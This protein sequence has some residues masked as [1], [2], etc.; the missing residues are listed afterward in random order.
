MLSLL[1]RWLQHRKRSSRQSFWGLG[2]S[3]GLRDKRRPFAAE[4]AASPVLRKLEPRRVLSITSASLAGNGVL[5]ITLDGA[6]DNVTLQEN[7]GQLEVLDGAAVNSTFDPTQVDS[8]VVN[9]GGG[10]D[11]VTFDPTT[12]ALSLP[13]V[14]G[15]SVVTDSVENL[16]F[17]G[18]HS[19]D[20]DLEIN[21]G[22]VTASAGSLTVSGATN[23]TAGTGDVLLD[24]ASNDFATMSISTSGNVSVA[25]ANDVSIDSTAIDGDLSITS[26]TG[27]AFTDPGAD[28][29][30]GGNLTATANGGDITDLNNITFDID[31]NASFT[32]TGIIQLA[33]NSL[34]T[35]DVAGQATFNAGGDVVIQP[36]GP[37]NG[38]TALFGSL[39][40]T[41]VGN[42][43]V[44]EDDDTLLTDADVD[45]DLVLESPGQLEIEQADVAGN[46]TFTAGL[47]IALIG[48]GDVE[49]GGDLVANANG[50]DITDLDDITIDVEGNATFTATANIQLADDALN[51]LDVASAATFDAG[52]DIVIQPTG[53]SNGANVVIGSLSLT[54]IGNSTVSEDDGT[55]LTA[56]D[57][58]G[59]LLLESAGQLLVEQADVEGNATFIAGLGVAFI[60][61]GDDV[62]VGGNLIATANGG[63]ITDLNDIT[64]DVGGDATFTATGDIQLAD[65]SLNVLGVV[66]QATF[67][68][69]GNVIIQPA[70]TSNAATVSFGS[71]SLTSVGNSTVSEDDDT[72]LTDA[73]VDGDLVVESA[74]QLQIQQA[75]VEGNATFTAGVGIAF[76][77]PGDVEVG[78]NLIVA[79]NAGGISDLD[80]ITI[81]VEGAAT[82][83]ATSNIELADDALNVLD[84]AGQATFDAGGDVLVQPAGSINGANVVFGSLSLTSTGDS[85]VSEDDGTILTDA[86]VD[87]N[88]VLETAGQMEIEQA[89]V[90][91]NA[92]FT[93]GLGIA[94]IAPG[95]N[96]E[97]GGNLTATANGGDITDLNIITIDV[98]GDATFTASGNIQLADNSLNMLLVTGSA[99]FEAGGDVVIQRVG[100]SNGANVLFGSLSLTSAANSTVSEDNVTLL[101]DA[102]VEG[103]LVLESAAQ[104]QIAQADV[105]G[106]AT[107]TAAL[108]ITFI[109][110]GD[111]VEVGGNLSA[112]ANGGNITDLND[113]TIDV[114]GDAL[115][116]ASGNIL[117]ADNPANTI[118]VAGK[119]TFTAATLVDV[120]GAVG[121]TANFDSLSLAATD[122]TV[123]EDSDT[124]F[125]GVSVNN[126]LSLNSEAV[127]TQSSQAVIV[128]GNTT[129]DL[130][131]APAHVYLARASSRPATNDG[132]PVDNQFD[133]LL[134]ITGA[135]LTSD[136]H[137]RNT[138]A[139]ATFPLFGATTQFNNLEIWHTAAN[140]AIP[141]IDFDIQQDLTIRSDGGNVTDDANTRLAVGNNAVY[142]ASQNIT[143]IADALIVIMD[144]D[145]TAQQAISATGN[146]LDVD[147]LARFVSV[148]DDSIEVN[149]G[150]TTFG[151][152]NFDGGDVN[153]T[154]DDGTLL[155]DSSDAVN[156][157]LRS[158]GNIDDAAGSINTLN[159]A[160]RALIN[161]AG[162]IVLGN[163]DAIVTFGHVA[164][165]TAEYLVLNANNADLNVESNV[166]LGDDPSLEFELSQL[167]LNAPGLLI[168][169]PQGGA[170]DIIQAD[171]VDLTA[172]AI[173]LKDVDFSQFTA[174]ATGSSDVTDS[175][176]LRLEELPMDI[177]NTGNT[178]TSMTRGALTPVNPGLN[179]GR[180]TESELFTFEL[181]NDYGVVISNHGDLMVNELTSSQGSV[182]IESLQVLDALDPT[183]VLED[184]N[185]L[186][187]ENVSVMGGVEKA[188]T[189]VAEGTIVISDGVLLQSSTGI[190]TDVGAFVAFS[191]VVIPPGL[192]NVTSGPLLQ[193]TQPNDVLPLDADGSNTTRTLD[194]V[195]GAFYRLQ[196]EFEIGRLG[197]TNFTVVVAYVDDLA[198]IDPDAGVIDV[199]GETYSLTAL[200]ADNESFVVGQQQLNLMTG[201]DSTF[202]V[203]ID[204]LGNGYTVEFST[205]V[206]DQDPAGTVD[207][208][209]VLTKIFSPLFPGENPIHPE[210][211]VVIRAFNDSLI[212]LYTA[213]VSQSDA[214]D[215]SLKLDDADGFTDLNESRVDVDAIDPLE[216]DPGKT[217]K[218]GAD[219][220][221]P[222]VVML[223]RF[224]LEGPL[225]D[226]PR[227]PERPP[228]FVAPP[229]PLEPAPEL[230]DIP[231]E[232][233][234]DVRPFVIA[235]IEEVKYGPVD[236]DSG[237]FKTQPPPEVWEG[238]T[239]GN[240][241]QEI[242]DKIDSDDM[243][244]PGPYQIEVQYKDGSFEVYSHVKQFESALQNDDGFDDLSEF[245]HPDSADVQTTHQDAWQM[246]APPQDDIVNADDVTV[247][248]DN[249]GVYHQKFTTRAS[250]LTAVAI[251]A[252]RSNHGA[253]SEQDKIQQGIA[254]ADWSRLA[255]LRRK[256]ATVLL[257]S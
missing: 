25:D 83:T 55:L 191:D 34:N 188:L 218:P 47:G 189:A 102:D 224:P 74:G 73:D 233:F 131:S 44:S 158:A 91:G 48:P 213:D 125:D 194:V 221:P 39:S 98:E 14:G 197:E 187:S 105:E 69:G 80:N 212:N 153:I 56:A 207:N 126:N 225:P 252:C 164:T 100:P 257:N 206:V 163:E 8:I 70:G 256:I 110:P 220:S 40:I 237:K 107:V 52:G 157:V 232:E 90:E 104:L 208:V 33:D 53:S 112:A 68:A 242:K 82:F 193:F 106:N 67:N 43:T 154:E 20:A 190:V 253:R 211:P 215:I 146:Q 41:S 114:D 198:F 97:V 32:A 186:F 85:T 5:T 172:G 10:T 179:G 184:G 216:L 159:V 139:T 16:L 95:E 246:W 149:A 113:I 92:T 31:G 124:H 129:L 11:T 141:A 178:G 36:A 37:S 6:D 2:A 117:L 161:A 176:V 72:L 77:G 13:G 89:D 214:L 88:L 19:L 94:F 156:L 62:E 248:L 78:G 130:R 81:D 46:G 204:D 87:T 235:A 71:L 50:G 115:F 132:A 152:L 79:A 238:G 119:A 167:V 9:D 203:G 15:D 201:F 135:G 151:S 49:V 42:S 174:V 60:N 148:S 227:P 58:D 1:G 84:V 116:T 30:V 223:A 147:G 93:A 109:Q 35:L 228:L 219:L 180:G 185:L 183:I 241:V 65:N 170:T 245:Q 202:D 22:S 244:E 250:A 138:S 236:E 120:G 155:R 29:I 169:Q 205:R 101:T 195:D 26:A 192:I 63:D 54:S 255:R 144:A 127:I 123:D 66:G 12:N 128:N 222:G 140:V 150:T 209:A 59:D 230:Q 234:D 3:W 28:V 27:I 199:G 142:T 254:S 17:A 210:A 122:A 45:G 217:N 165:N 137:I 24:N 61:P 64:I 166:N 177:P 168:A 229:P 96:V 196:A 111:D 23:I 108:G 200:A 121:A 4:F 181:G 7:A 171:I 145:F 57:V 118:D 231:P 240:F 103:N 143:L 226:A 38:A 243:Y 182:Y 134:T 75:D 249:D 18:A 251:V 160:D 133:G 76:I 247:A 173:I 51:V 175:T 99:A 136:V 21:A 239:A 86:D 162:D